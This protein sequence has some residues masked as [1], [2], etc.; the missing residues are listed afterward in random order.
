MDADVLYAGDFLWWKASHLP[1]AE[2]PTPSEFKGEKWTCD[3]RAAE[4]YRANR[5]KGANKPGLGQQCIHLNGNSGYQAIN[6][7]YLFGARHIVLV[8]F[9][10]KLGPNG[11]K[12]HHKDHP[13]T[14]VQGQ[15][16]GQWL[17]QGARLAKDLEA[18]A[19]DVVNCTADTALTCFRKSTLEKE[20]AHAATA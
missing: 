12:H 11:E 1:L 4:V 2:K 20:L 15:T 16:F 13:A 7:A 18:H 19:C 6:L 14:C 8:G 3:H 9:D 17:L 5:I 10:M